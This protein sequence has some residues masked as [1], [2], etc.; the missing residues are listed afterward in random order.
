MN[1]LQQIAQELDTDSDKLDFASAL[2]EA[3]QQ[4]L[5]DHIRSAR[6]AHER[7]IHQSMQQALEHFPRILRGPVKKVFGL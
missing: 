5:L 1:H 4:Q 3:E 6:K 7:H 2:G